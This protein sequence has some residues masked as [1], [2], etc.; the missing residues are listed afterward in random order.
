MKKVIV[1]GAGVGGLATAI[2]LAVKGYQ[3]DVFEAN[4]VVGGKMAQIESNNFRFDAGP[5]LFTMPEL[6]DEL[7][8]LCGK[9]PKE[10]FEYEKLDENCKY[11]YEDG[12]HITAFSKPL[13]FAN[14]VQLKTNAS[15]QSVLKHLKKSAFIYNATEQLFLK[16]SLHKIKTYFSFSTLF[17]FLKLPFLNIFNTMDSVNRK[18]LK[19]PRIVQLFNRFSTYNGSNPY[20]APG[21]LNIIPHLEFNKGA[22]FPKKGMRSIPEVLYKLCLEKNVQ[23]HLNTKVTAIQVSE[24]K[25]TGVFVGN[26]IFKAD[27]VVCNTDVYFVYK[28]LLPKKYFLKNILTQ[29]RSTSALI[30]YWGVNKRFKQLGLHNIFFSENYEKEFEFL[31]DGKTVYDDPTVYINISSKIKKDDAPKDAENWFVM[32]NVPSN[33]GQD[34]NNIK[35]EVKS[36]IIAKLNRALDVDLCPLIEFEESLD[37]ILIESKTSSYKGSLYG[38]ASNSKMSAFFRHPNFS[39]QIKGLYFCGGSVHPG[40]GIPLA[41]SSAKIIVDLIKN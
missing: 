28:N 36:N 18:R 12:T 35:H 11:F 2:R 33:N 17:S 31:N 34:W 30:F 3:V 19:D 8:V 6:V 16:K 37:P 41:L 15:S 14:E 9:D 10:Y 25:A 21:I 27:L 39:S 29:E 38:T 26:D 13:D 23:F 20:K 4:S 40:G 24:E 5:S 1:I 32:V 7:I 22:F